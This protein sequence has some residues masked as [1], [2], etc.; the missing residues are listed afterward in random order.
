MLSSLTTWCT[1]RGIIV[2]F[3]KAA[4]GAFFP[5]EK[6]IEINARLKPENQVY[7]LLHECGHVLI[8]H[9]N[10]NE[11][12]GMGYPSSNVPR[13]ARRLTHKCDVIDEELEAWYRGFKLSR[14]LKFNV[15]KQRFDAFKSKMIIS[16][17]KWA[18]NVGG[19]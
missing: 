18:L 13:I 17:M 14:R 10:T 2:E 9:K 19:F 7:C 1:K 12:F 15:D 3:K 4:N 8:G 5:D 11:R 6:R 16:Y